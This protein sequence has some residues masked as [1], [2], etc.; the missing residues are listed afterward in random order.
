[1]GIYKHLFAF[2]LLL[3]GYVYFIYAAFDNST[4]DQNTCRKYQGMV[5]LVLGEPELLEA[6][7]S[8]RRRDVSTNCFEKFTT[9]FPTLENI[10]GGLMS[11]ASRL[12][13]DAWDINCL[14]KSV[15]R[16]LFHI[17]N[18]H[19]FSNNTHIIGNITVNTT[20][21][22]TNMSSNSSL[23]LDISNMMVTLLHKD[24][25][26]HTHVEG[27]NTTW[28]WCMPDVPGKKLHI[29]WQDTLIPP[30]W[31]VNASVQAFGFDFIN[32][33]DVDQFVSEQ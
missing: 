8:R 18:E 7:A 28:P 20:Y 29:I 1:M 24:N 4:V 17:D 19:F 15:M 32:R 26:N 2:C 16:C 23:Q 27:R 6:N 3:V 14:S 30:M 12:R 11:H 33:T 10:A 9:Q 5:L 21:I 22:H 13:R 31:L 25:L